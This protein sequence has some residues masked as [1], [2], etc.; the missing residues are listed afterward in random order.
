MDYSLGGAEGWRVGT[1]DAEQHWLRATGSIDRNAFFFPISY[2]FRMLVR[3]RLQILLPLLMII[4][5][6]CLLH[7]HPAY[8]YPRPAHYTNPCLS[9]P[10][11]CLLYHHLLIR[12]YVDLTYCFPRRHFSIIL[13]P[14]SLSC[15]RNG[16]LR[17]FPSFPSLSLYIYAYIRLSTCA[18]AY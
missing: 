14:P 13:I 8:L 12:I 9:I 1:M 17:S 7:P 15:C 10:Q 11:S 5:A 6:L 4:D 18:Q 16:P 3:S 2:S